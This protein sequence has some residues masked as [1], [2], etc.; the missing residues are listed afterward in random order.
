MIQSISQI[1]PN[2][3][4]MI[5]ISKTSNDQRI[6]VQISKLPDFFDNKQISLKKHRDEAWINTKMADQERLLLRYRKCDDCD[7]KDWCQKQEAELEEDEDGNLIEEIPE[8]WVCED[9][10]YEAFW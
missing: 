8:Q 3:C 2:D 10:Y 9:C 1:L 7:C 5:P 4:Q 6:S